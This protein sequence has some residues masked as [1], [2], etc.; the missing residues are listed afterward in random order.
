MDYP[1]SV[2]SA[3]LVN[4]K[5]VDENPL[6]GTPGSLIPADWGNGVTQEI[7]NVIKAGDLTP[8]EKKYDQLLQAI[9][10]VSAKGW[11]LD[12]ASPIGSL[13]AA[14]VA[15]PDG[16]LAIT[17]AAVATSGGRVSIPAGV[18]ISLGQ[19]V[20]AGQLGRSRT[21]T[22]QLWSS[23][24]LLP[25]T[26][27]FLRAQVIA[28]VLTF[29]MQRGT[30]YDATPEGLKGTVNGAAGG[31]FQST[32]LDICL[33]WV[34]TAG[35][36]SIPT[37][38]AIY[39][40]SRLSWTQTVNG[41]GVVYLPLDP[42]ARAARLVVGNP[43]PHPTGITTVAF[44][45]GGWLG[46]NYSYLNP[47]VTTSSNWDGWSTVGAS[48]GIFTSNVVNDTT[49]S[50]LSASFD[51]AELRSLWQVFQSEHTLGSGNASSDELLFGMGIKS[52]SQA[53]YSNGIA[54]NFASA[55]N[56]HL[57]WELIR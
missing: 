23:P 2:P 7:L 45:P 26:G 25:S 10:S 5:F 4:G 56:V 44:A 18:L 31:G 21:F 39:N 32:P 40:R 48:V 27:Y 11:N 37:V 43:T 22:T 36:G 14:T 19:E 16:R 20:I 15:T 38:R 30:I 13:P 29:Y 8:D 34:V 28:G 33:A 12:S 6:T 9:Q 49:V 35:P 1:N 54:I 46:G 52:F 51:H 50:T 42:H 3:G 55:I 53:D 24:D 57:S 17:P 41:N 47:T